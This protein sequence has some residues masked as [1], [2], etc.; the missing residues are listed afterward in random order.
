MNITEVIETLTS[1]KEDFG[2]VEVKIYTSLENNEISVDVIKQIKS[3]SVPEVILG[4]INSSCIIFI[5]N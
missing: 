4:K 2:N 1:L 3:I 5:Q